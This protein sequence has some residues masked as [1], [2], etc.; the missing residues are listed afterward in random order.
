MWTVR[1]LIEYFGDTY[2]DRVLPQGVYEHGDR[3]RAMHFDSLGRTLKSKVVDDLMEAMD[4]L[5]SW[6]DDHHWWGVHHDPENHFGFLYRITEKTTGKMYI[7]SKQYWVWNGP[8]AGYKCTDVTDEEWW[9]PKL[10]KENDWKNY[11]GS[12]VP[13]NK[14]IEM[15]PDNYFYEVISLHKDKLDL[16]LS[17][18]ELQVSENVLEAELPDGSFRYYNANIGRCLFKAPL[19]K[20][21]MKELEAQ[22]LETAKEKIRAYIT[23]PTVCSCGAVLAFGEEP[24]CKE[25]P[26]QI[27]PEV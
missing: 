12:C 9:N 21:Q 1:N 24:C 7:G 27:F 17:E 15:D 23:K 20:T 10:W 14:M 19:S 11:T 13:L 3:L 18:I 26:K 5:K 2:K 22:S 4:L 8:T 6:R 16:M 25:K